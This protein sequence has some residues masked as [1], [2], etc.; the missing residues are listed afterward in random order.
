MLNL[1]DDSTNHE[2]HVDIRVCVSSLVRPFKFHQNN[3]FLPKTVADTLHTLEVALDRIIVLT[4]LTPD[5]VWHSNSPPVTS[6]YVPRANQPPA[7]TETL[8]LDCGVPR[9]ENAIQFARPIV[10]QRLRT[11]QFADTSP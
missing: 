5:M 11:P 2:F 8:Q 7:P 3:T 9:V 1:C 10:H 4:L 6:K